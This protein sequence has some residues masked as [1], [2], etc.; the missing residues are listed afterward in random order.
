MGVIT[1]QDALQ[2]M[3]S[4]EPFDITFVKADRKR[5]TGGQIRNE[6]GAV[7]EGIDHA[8]HQRRIKLSSG[9]IRRVHIRLMTQ[10]NGH[11][12]VY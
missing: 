2:Q 11:N 1:L 5:G 6:R 8:N 10:F 12:I 3:G 4:G 7:Q 9:R